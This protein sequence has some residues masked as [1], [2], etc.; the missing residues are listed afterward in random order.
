M[1]PFLRRLGG[2]SRVLPVLLPLVPEFSG[3]L[4]APF[5]GGGALE[6]NLLGRLPELRSRAIL[7]DADGELVACYVG[8]Q[9]DPEGVAAALQR[10]Q[11]G[12]EGFVQLRDMAAEA[13]LALSPAEQAARVL[14]LNVQSFNGLARRN[15]AGERN[16]A[17]AEFNPRRLPAL[18]QRIK[19][20]SVA[21][22]GVTL[23][24][25][26]FEPVLAGAGDGDFVFADCPYDATFTAYTGRFDDADQARLATALRA[27]AERGGRFL[28]TN[29]DTP[30]IRE[31]FS[32][33]TFQVVPVRYNVS[34]DGGARKAH[35]EVAIMSHGLQ[36]LAQERTQSASN[37]QTVAA[38]TYSFPTEKQAVAAN[39]PQSAKRLRGAGRLSNEAS[40]ERLDFASELLKA[41]VGRP[42]SLEAFREKYQ[43]STRTADTYLAAAKQAFAAEAVAASSGP[44]LVEARKKERELFLE[45]LR[46]DIAQAK[47]AGVWSAVSSLRKLEC[48]TRGLRLVPSPESPAPPA[49]QTSVVVNNLTL[50]AG[51]LSPEIR[52]HR[53]A[54]L[55]RVLDSELSP[56]ADGT[57]PDSEPAPGQLAITVQ[58]TSLESD[59]SAG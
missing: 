53:L 48:D 28:E 54:L 42:K 19:Q 6:M 46:T 18:V 17:F 39:N 20:A 59:R 33:Y 34:G 57:D 51:Q 55:R 49:A 35:Q 38:K 32:G 50:G 29:S 43:A 37:A 15:G 13:V 24:A 2:K 30:K 56:E 41:G 5:V 11:W 45:D 40:R 21:L 58:G 47:A 8:V 44:G 25:S 12:R 14:S 4:I 1:K 22:Q 23:A 16:E 10:Q 7:S 36:Q 52:A 31:L 9:T 27:F 3:R 26:D